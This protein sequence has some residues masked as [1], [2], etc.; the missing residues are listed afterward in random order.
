[1]PLLRC[2]KKRTSSGMGV[3]PDPS[4]GE[5][6]VI[7]RPPRVQPDLEPRM[8]GTLLKEQ[9]AQSCSSNDQEHLGRW[10]GQAPGCC[11]RRKDPWLERGRGSR[12]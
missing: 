12:G 10:A 1:M 4:T 11:G 5:P 3:S 2:I 8:N 7:P 6:R 9:W